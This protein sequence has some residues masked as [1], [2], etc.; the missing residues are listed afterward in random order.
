MHIPVVEKM[1]REQVPV[2]QVETAMVSESTRQEKKDTTRE[3]CLDTT[4]SVILC[5]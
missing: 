5:P 3:I 4:Y 2:H 1:H